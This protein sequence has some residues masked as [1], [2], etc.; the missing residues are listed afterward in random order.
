[1]RLWTLFD[2]RVTALD[3][4]ESAVWEF[5]L[6]RV[7]S[8]EDIPRKNRADFL[9]EVGRDAYPLRA[10]AGRHAQTVNCREY[11]DQDKHQNQIAGTGERTNQ[12]PRSRFPNSAS[13]SITV[14]CRFVF[15]IWY[16][17]TGHRSRVTADSPSESERMFFD[18]TGH[19]MLPLLPH[20][21]SSHHTGGWGGF[22]RGYISGKFSLRKVAKFSRGEI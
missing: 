3:M 12:S 8:H 17:V 7:R 6:V 2:L 10:V 5:K 21:T 22:G 4:L 13:A 1:M 11:D 14:S 20:L 16:R 15:A 18:E 9:T 19:K